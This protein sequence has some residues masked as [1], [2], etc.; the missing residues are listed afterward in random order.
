[1]IQRVKDVLLGQRHVAGSVGLV[2]KFRLGA[3]PITDAEKAFMQFAPNGLGAG[4]RTLAR[5]DEGMARLFVEHAAPVIAVEMTQVI[6]TDMLRA[7]EAA[8]AL[9]NHAY[10]K[11]LLAQIDGAKAQLYREYEVVSDRYGN[12]QTLLAYYRDLTE[13]IKGRRYLTAEQ[14]HAGALTQP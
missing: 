8:S 13:Q 10:A 1:M 3:G 6:L 11:Q 12:A 7:V 9:D 4:V 5:Y 2:Q 14:A